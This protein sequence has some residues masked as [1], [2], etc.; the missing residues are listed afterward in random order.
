M[1]CSSADKI[2]FEFML[3][4]GP[5][6][7]MTFGQQVDTTGWKDGAPLLFDASGHLTVC[8]SGNLASASGIFGIAAHPS[9]TTETVDGVAQQTVYMC[10]PQ[11]VFSMAVSN[12]GATTSVPAHTMVNNG[13]LIANSGTVSGSSEVWV[14]DVAA[15]GQLGGY[16][17]GLKDSTTKIHGRVYVIINPRVYSTNSP[18]L[19]TSTAVG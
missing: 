9:N 15:T 2:K 4:G 8:S 5:P 16:V 10:T 6:V 17:V 3:G 7:M 11:T 19:V 18:F 1:A 14:L 12:A 13:Y